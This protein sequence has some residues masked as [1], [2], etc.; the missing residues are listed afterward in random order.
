MPIII[1]ITGELYGE[2]LDVHAIQGMGNMTNMFKFKHGWSAELSG[3]YRT[4][5]IEGQIYVQ[6]MGQTSTAIAKQIMKEKGTLKLGLRDIFYTQQVKGTID[7]QQTQATFHNT[8]DSRQLS[9]TFTYRFG[10]AIKGAQ[11]NQHSGGADDESSRLK[12]GGNN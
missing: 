8:R 5:G 6:P 12:K 7:F 11:N 10:Q 9:L 3:W 2:D 4:S 1:I